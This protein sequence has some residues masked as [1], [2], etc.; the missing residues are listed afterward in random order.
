MP[1]WSLGGKETRRW[2][3]PRKGATK[4]AWEVKVAASR[5]PASRDS[6]A[7]RQ[8]GVE[9]V[10]VFHLFLSLRHALL[11]R[12]RPRHSDWSRAA[13]GGRAS[14]SGGGEGAEN[15]RLNFC[16]TFDVAEYARTARSAR[17]RASQ[18][19]S[20]REGDGV[21][22]AAAGIKS[23]HKNAYAPVHKRSKHGTP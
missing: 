14:E 3:S 2:N 18:Q 7:L 6:P 21:H 10:L 11:P 1:S 8:E 15:S 22:A 20:R 17:S 9:E 16:S 5:C 4:H 13:I 19:I 12:V 23:W